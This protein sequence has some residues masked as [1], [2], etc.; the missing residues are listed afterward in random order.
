VILLPI[1]SPGK[2]G[3]QSVRQFHL[4]EPVTQIMPGRQPL[5]RHLD[6]IR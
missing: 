4:L 5:W 3:A 1:A 6:F 2:K